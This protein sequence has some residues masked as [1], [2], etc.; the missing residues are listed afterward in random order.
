MGQVASGRR[1]EGVV[2][3]GRRREGVEAGGPRRDGVV[4][5]SQ[6]AHMK[7]AVVGSRRRKEVRA[8]PAARRKRKAA[9][10]IGPKMTG[11]VKNLA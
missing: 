3:G 6:E 1:R 5:A 4:I 11:A 8:S 9:V 10:R 2:A 7:E